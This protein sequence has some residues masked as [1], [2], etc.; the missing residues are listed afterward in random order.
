[1]R[2]EYVD[3][4]YEVNPNHPTYKSD[5]YNY[6]EPF[7]TM[8]VAYKF[9]ER[10][11]ISLFYNRRVDRPNEVDIRIFPKYDDAEIVKVGNP[12]LHPQ[13]TISTE[14]GFKTSWNTGN[15]YGALYHKI[16]DGTITRIST[17]IPGN[18]LIYAIFQNAG[19][20]Y[21]SGFEAILTQ[22]ISNFYTANLNG[23]IY[24]NRINAFTVENKYPIQH[25]F[26]A[27]RQ[28]MYSGNVKLNNLFRPGAQFEMQVSAVWLAPDI[29]PQGKIQSRF[30]LD[31]GLKKTIQKGKG[32]LIL[33]ATD[34]LNTMAI[35]KEIQGDTFSYTLNNQYETQ[36]VRIG[37]NYKF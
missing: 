34:L 28:N 33:S 24:Y 37:Y 9:N 26:S 29:I 3:L 21:N 12:A 18:D 13:F 36:V 23:N 6:I 32:E 31:L 15:W 7:A 2:V 20:S 19:R 27:D 25:T 1:M 5:G 22:N 17:V 10:N 11:K 4:K 30:S 35:R 8:R 16:T 14:L